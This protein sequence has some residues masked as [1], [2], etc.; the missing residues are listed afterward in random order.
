MENEKVGSWGALFVVTGLYTLDGGFSLLQVLR[1]LLVHSLAIKKNHFQALDRGSGGLRPLRLQSDCV[2]VV[3]R[4]LTVRVL[5][6][7]VLL[8]WV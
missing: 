3:G 6:E 5:E 2:Q 4:V 1:K 7:E 8:R